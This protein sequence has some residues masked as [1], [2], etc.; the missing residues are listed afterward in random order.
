[1][2]AATTR[3]TRGNPISH[4]KPMTIA[5]SRPIKSVSQNRR[6]HK[7]EILPEEEVVDV[8]AGMNI[9]RWIRIISMDRRYA[10]FKIV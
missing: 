8:V 6:R 1:M 9:A 2:I 5:P 4:A 3:P 7:A 10:S